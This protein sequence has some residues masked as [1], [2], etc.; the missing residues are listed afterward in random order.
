MADDIYTY[1]IDL[2]TDVEE[3]VLPCQGG[4]TV[5]INA[6]LTRERQELAYLHALG[7]II[8]GEADIINADVDAIEMAAHRRDSYGDGEKAR[9]LVEGARP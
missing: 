4:Y 1:F 8:N 6:Q 9:R 2:P 5:Y 3:A 7:H